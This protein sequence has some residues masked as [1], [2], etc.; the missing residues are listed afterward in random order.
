MARTQQPSTT[1]V[2]VPQEDGEISI[3]RNGDLDDP[4]VYTVTSGTVEVDAADVAHF[5]SV[6]TGAELADGTPVAPA[7][8]PDLSA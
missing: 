5:L 1:S 6:V 3:T 8:A 2:R 7:D 4:T